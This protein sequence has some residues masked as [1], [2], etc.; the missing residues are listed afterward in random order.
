MVLRPRIDMHASWTEHSMLPGHA[1]CMACVIFFRALLCSD[2]KTRNPEQ[3]ACPQIDVASCRSYSRSDWA[4]I[5]QDAVPQLDQLV[6]GAMTR[7]P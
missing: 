4:E 6:C 5:D 2:E 3:P 1:N 7:S